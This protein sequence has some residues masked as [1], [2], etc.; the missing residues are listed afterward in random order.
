MDWQAGPNF[1]NEQKL[2]RLQY[3]GYDALTIDPNDPNLF[4]FSPRVVAANVNDR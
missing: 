1:N 3:D 2:Q 4:E